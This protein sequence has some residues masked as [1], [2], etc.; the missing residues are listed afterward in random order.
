MSLTGKFTFRRTMTGKI[1]LQV[2]EERAGWFARRGSAPRRRWRDATLMDLT[3]PE[4][5]AL[6][7]LRLKPRFLPQH[8]VVASGAPALRENEGAAP[9]A[10]YETFPIQ[11]APRKTAH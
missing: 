7:D 11:D 4:M 2:E 8:H 6:I 5:R 10:S 9:A 1:V 3:Q